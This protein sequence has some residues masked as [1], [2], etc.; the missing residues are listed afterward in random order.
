MGR[1]VI[2]PLILIE[3][4][5]ILVL[6]LLEVVSYL[7]LLKFVNKALFLRESLKLYLPFYQDYS[8]REAYNN[9]IINIFIIKYWNKW[10][11]FQDIYN[12]I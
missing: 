3:Q 7:L 2:V 5:S 8:F 9:K 11:L 1:K 6:L 12:I 10:I 4:M